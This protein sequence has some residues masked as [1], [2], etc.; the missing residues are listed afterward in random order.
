MNSVWQQLTLM[1]LSFPRW[2]RSS[3]VGHLMGLVS[4]WG[5]GSWLVQSGTE[6]SGLLIALVLIVGP[7]VSTG[8]IGLLLFAGAGLWMFLTLAEDPDKFGGP[9]PIHLLVF[10]YWAIAS[11][12]T[13]LSPVKTEALKGW[14]KLSLYL[15]AFALIERVVRSPRWRSWLITIYLHVA[16]VVSAYGLRQWFFG[17]DALATWVD[18]ESATATVTRVYS[19]LG[20]P[21]LLAAYLL[22]AIPLSL[23]ACFAWRG[24]LPKLLGA[25]LFILNSACLILSSS[26]G[27]WIGWVVEIF[28]CSLLLLYWWLPHLP[29]FW[30]IWTFPIV[31]GGLAGIL[32]LGILFVEPL[33]DRVL[34][35]FAGRKDSSNNFRLNVWAAALDMIRDRPIIGIGPGNDAFN[36]IYPLF[37]RPNFSALSAY[38]IYLDIA[39][40]TGLIGIAGFLWLL[41]VI[42]QRSWLQIQQFRQHNSREIFW[43]IAAVAAVMG[44]L[45]HGLVDTVWSRPQVNT[46]WWFMVAIIAS[47]SRLI[48]PQP[49]S[50]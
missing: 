16:L 48:K 28:V 20:N 36:R 49:Q 11:V 30:R 24:W 1:H 44:L 50:E 33:R 41:L 43:L 46:L 12:A 23:G 40:E 6:L 25:T 26:R 29:R 32:C 2:R 13:V 47:Y 21:N 39:V 18:P 34:S 27:G 15:L 35:I 22:P 5:R 10:L 8:L 4:P 19:Y 14:G 38:S 17:A 9:T 31:L 3:Y 7:F 37:Q 45:A 42:F